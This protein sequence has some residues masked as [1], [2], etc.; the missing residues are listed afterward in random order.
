MSRTVKKKVIDE[1]LEFADNFDESMLD[2]IEHDLDGDPEADQAAGRKRSSKRDS[3]EDEEREGRA[4]KAQAVAPKAEETPSSATIGQPPDKPDSDSESKEPQKLPIYRKIALKK[5]TAIGAALLLFVVLP[6]LAWMKIQGQ[7]RQTPVI[8]FVRHPVPVPNFQ[9][10][11]KFMLL[12][13]SESKKDIVEMNLQFDFSS[14]SAIER[15]REKQTSIQDSCY[16]FMQT[17]NLI[18]SSQKSWAR[19][20]QR[21]LLAHLQT[22]YPKV[23]IQAITLTEFTRL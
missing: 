5:W 19:L 20:V 17:N 7:N 18:D 2:R 6:A 9:I 22:S 14:E 1:T 3:P 11:A 21:D 4:P 13:G 10:E 12:S 15:F 8:Q 23:N 16:R